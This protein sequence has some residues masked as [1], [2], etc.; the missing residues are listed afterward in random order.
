M[1]KLLPAVLLSAAALGVAA[2]GPQAPVTGVVAETMDSGGYTYVR[3]VQD[4]GSVWLAAPPTKV[5]KGQ[6]LSFQ[7]GMAMRNFKSRTLKRTFPAIIFSPGL[8]SGTS[9]GKGRGAMM[10]G[11]GSSEAAPEAGLKVA[12]AE[13]PSAF[14]VAELHARRKELEGKDVTVRGKVVKVSPEIMGR[15]WLHLQDGTGDAKAGTHDITVTTKDLPKAGQ[16]VTVK[17]KVAADKDIG[18]G[19]FYPVLVE[20]AA[21]K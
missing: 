19:Y 13:G 1:I 21:V 18:A 15:N 11:H 12:K 7:P 3:L 8:V 4:Q 20:D 17:G 14:T 9:T 2:P 5:A 16:V 6:K 10:P